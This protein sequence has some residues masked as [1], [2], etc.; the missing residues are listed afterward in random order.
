MPYPTLS[1]FILWQRV[2]SHTKG[3]NP[4]NLLYVL[5]QKG[6]IPHKR[7]YPHFYRLN[8]FSVARI[9]CNDVAQ[10]ES[11]H[12][13]VFWFT[14]TK[15]SYHHDNSSCTWVWRNISHQNSTSLFYKESFNDKYFK[16]ALFLQQKIEHTFKNKSKEYIGRE[17]DRGINTDKKNNIKA[18]FDLIPANRREFYNNIKTNDNAVDLIVS[19]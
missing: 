5:W 18:L 7:V 9:L 19:H 12:S 15:H 2:L 11:Q 14:L 4:H 17:D 8:L 13:R 6:P 3:P 16:E 1:C 10:I